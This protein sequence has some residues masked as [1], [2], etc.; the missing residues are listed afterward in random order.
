MQESHVLTDYGGRPEYDAA[1][2]ADAWPNVLA[3]LRG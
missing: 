3:C 1:A 2:H